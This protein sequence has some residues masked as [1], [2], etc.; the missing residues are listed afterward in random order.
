MR[1]ILEDQNF[2]KLQAET[3]F[4]SRTIITTNKKNITA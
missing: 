1:E 3:I 4:A 2:P